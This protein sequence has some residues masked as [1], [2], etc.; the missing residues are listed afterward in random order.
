MSATQG[1]GV[2]SATVWAGRTRPSCSRPGK[3]REEGDP[4]EEGSLGR[5]LHRPELLQLPTH[6]SQGT[7]HGQQGCVRAVPWSL[8]HQGARR[9]VLT[10]VSAEKGLE[11]SPHER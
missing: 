3:P 11:M 10:L 5:R 7:E 9:Q 1:A 2:S 8:G 4:R 6:R